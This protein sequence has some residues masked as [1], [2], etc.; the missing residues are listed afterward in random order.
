MRTPG[1]DED[2]VRGFLVTERVVDRVE[3]IAAVRHCDIVP[4]PEAENNIVQVTLAPGVRVDLARLRRNM[5]ASSSCGICGK[6][7][8]DQAMQSA[9][10]LHDPIRVRATLL[11][12]LPDRLRAVQA[13]FDQ[14]GGLH[15]AGLFDARGELI[16]ARED[17]GRHN[18]VDKVVGWATTHHAF[19]L[20]GSILMVSGRLSFEIT[21]KALAARIPIIAAVSAPS[22]LAIDLAGAA[23][24]TVAAFVRGQRLCVYA[25]AERV[26]G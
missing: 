11:Y 7:S 21:Q 10:P 24:M 26:E 15:A 3:D 16:V 5:F 17:I 6:A 9:E 1:H 13:V 4:T 2:L 25:G 8:L 22:S 18:A 12:D 19:P 20:A 23:G 14:T